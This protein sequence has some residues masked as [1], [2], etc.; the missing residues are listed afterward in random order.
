[1]ILTQYSFIK[2]ILHGFLSE[3]PYS[4]SIKQR[5]TPCASIMIVTA[6]ST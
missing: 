4:A 2:E 3:L 1:M 6:T 5:R